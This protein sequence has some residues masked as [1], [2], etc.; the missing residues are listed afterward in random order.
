MVDMAGWS[1]FVMFAVSRRAFS[2][3]GRYASRPSPVSTRMYGLCLP[4]RYVFVPV[5]MRLG[6]R[7]AYADVLGTLEGEFAPVLDVGWSDDWVDWTDMLTWPRT[8]IT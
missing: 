4:T 1:G 3:M 8:R 2:R 6:T 5:E 7:T